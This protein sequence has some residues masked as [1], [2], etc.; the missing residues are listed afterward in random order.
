MLVLSRKVEQ[1]LMIGD[2]I[3]IVV[4][5][6]G[7]NRVKLGI[8]APR[9]TKVRRFELAPHGPTP[10]GCRYDV[11]AGMPPP[12]PVDGSGQGSTHTDAA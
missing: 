3:V 8:E 11:T 5:H 10:N 2:D 12:P 9:T 6:I 1:R 7:E 4:T